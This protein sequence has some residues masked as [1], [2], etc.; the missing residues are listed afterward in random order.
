VVFGWLAVDVEVLEPIK[1]AHRGDVVHTFML[2]TDPPLMINPPGTVEPKNGETFLLGLAPTTRTN[3]F[4]AV[5]APFDDKESIF[6][7]DRSDPRYSSYRKGAIRRR[8]DGEILG[9]PFK[10][11]YS[12][13]WHL[14]NDEG[15]ILPRGAERMRKA[16]A[17]QIQMHTAP[18]V[19][20]LQWET[21]TNF[22]RVAVERTQNER[23]GLKPDCQMTTQN[24]SRQPTPGVRLA[25]HRASA[26]RRG[27]PLRSP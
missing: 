20:Y 24:Q 7:L 27:C 19:I 16:F 8:L 23:H 22:R 5:T 15:G 18:T 10:E 25:A 21:R 3:V 26:A 11:Q 14:V 13:V 17:K 1:G 12:W 4:A 9:E 6:R 2:F